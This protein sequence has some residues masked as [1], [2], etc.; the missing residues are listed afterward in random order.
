MDP[1]DASLLT[2]HLGVTAL[3]AARAVGLA[4]TAPGW[5]APGIDPRVRVLLGVLIAVSVA[6]LVGCLAVPPQNLANWCRALVSEAVVG[7]GLG[8]IAGLVVE[9]ARQGG[10]I[11]ASAAG[12]SASTFFDP[13]TGGESTPLGRL[14]GL[15][16]MLV[17]IGLDGPPALL[18]VLVE[19]YQSAP[20][21]K[22]LESGATASVLFAQTQQA[23]GLAIRVAAPTTTSL[24]LAGATIA[25]MGRAGAMLTAG[26]TTWAARML[27][28]LVVTI[29]GLSLL[30]A[31][32]DTGW[33]E[34]L[35]GLT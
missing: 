14:H 12:L 3:V 6:P 20:L 31:T 10:E 2:Q 11:I 33:R 22:A 28:G 29:L 26:A 34:T 18:G 7:A 16:A 13:D 30:A 19:S 23:L 4:A 8:L 25:W 17:F 21:G 32:L 5:S 15:I 9:A 35:L 27:L 24:L 1:G